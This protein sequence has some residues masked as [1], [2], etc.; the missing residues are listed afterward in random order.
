[1]ASENVLT[2]TDATFESEIQKAEVPV[3]VDFWAEWCG[4]CRHFAPV[5]DQFASENAGKVIAAK[6]D[7][8]SNQNVAAKYNI[9][10]IPTL[11]W[12]KG[13]NFLGQT[14]AM[15]KDGLLK[16]LESL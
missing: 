11:L 4:P 6:V 7:V 15:S 12:F 9:R 14:S 16:K 10:Q 13:G 5:F 3:V 2:L 8:D 1:M